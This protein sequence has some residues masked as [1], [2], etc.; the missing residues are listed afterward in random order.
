MSHSPSCACP[1]C[2][3]AGPSLCLPLSQHFPQPSAT[4]ATLE[5][6]NPNFAQ[7]PAFSPPSPDS[8]SQEGIW[9]ASPVHFHPH[10][11]LSFPKAPPLP[12]PLCS[13]N[14]LPSYYRVKQG[15]LAHE[16][17]H[18]SASPIMGVR[19]SGLE[20]TRPPPGKPP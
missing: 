7:P 3:P 8:Q 4:A 16:S 13:E 6:P 19:A 1:L 14:A 10:S 20:V 12:I 2:P 18:L 15:V 17:P 11:S 9:V 5:T